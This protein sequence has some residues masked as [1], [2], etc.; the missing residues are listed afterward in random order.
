[1]NQEEIIDNALQNNE[2]IR[3]AILWAI[4]QEREECAIVCKERAEGYKYTTDIYALV[5]SAEH[6]AEANNCAIAIRAR[7]QK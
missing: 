2:S 3:N 1:M 7:G 5:Y 6:I 4:K